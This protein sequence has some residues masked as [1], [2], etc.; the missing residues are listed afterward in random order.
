MPLTTDESP[1]VVEATYHASAA[2]VWAALTEPDQM[3]DWYFQEMDD[4]EPSVGFKSRFVVNLDD[5]SY[6]H[7]WEVVESD[8][9]RCLAYLWSYDDIPGEGKVT[10]ELSEA[11]GVTHLRLTNEIL[12]DFSVDDPH[13]TFDSCQ[14]GWEFILQESLKI[15]LE[16]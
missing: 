2:E 15:Y 13:F 16:G 3:R 12:A 4:F 9:P 8:P 7:N 6:P 11:D 1:I 14:S 10:W 5:K